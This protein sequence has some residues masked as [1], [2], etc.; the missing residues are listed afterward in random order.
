MASS[1]NFIIEDWVALASAALKEEYG[2]KSFST[3]KLEAALLGVLG[4]Q[5]EWSTLQPLLPYAEL[6]KSEFAKHEITCRAGKWS[7]TSAAKKSKP[8]AG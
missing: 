8:A 1:S 3:Y 2:T 7:H 6:I 5:A 4:K